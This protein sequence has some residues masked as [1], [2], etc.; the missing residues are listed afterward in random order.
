[1]D[2]KA[3]D[4]IDAR[5]KYKDPEVRYCVTKI[6]PPV[7]ILTTLGQWWEQIPF[8]LKIKMKLKKANLVRNRRSASQKR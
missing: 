5:C 1:L 7:C 2:N 4:I 6:P 3:F 8:L